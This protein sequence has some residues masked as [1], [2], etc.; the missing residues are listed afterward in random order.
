MRALPGDCTKGARGVLKLDSVLRPEYDA[1]PCTHCRLVLCAF[2]RLTTIRRAHRACVA[3]HA[4]RADG[5]SQ[6]GLLRWLCATNDVERVGSC[7]EHLHNAA[8]RRGAVPI[9]VGVA[10]KL[11]S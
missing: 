5:G 4:R 2:V 6:C 7:R 11:V 3:G 1:T 8:G 9:R 10:K